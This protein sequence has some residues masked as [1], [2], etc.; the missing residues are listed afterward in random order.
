MSTEHGAGAERQV[1]AGT[2]NS[3][4]TENAVP[5]RR[6]WPRTLVNRWPT[7]MALLMTVTTLGGA[8]SDDGV[9]TFSG[10]LLLLPLLYLV[11][12]K[13]GRRRATWPLL[14]AGVAVIFVLEGLELIAPAAVFTAIA[15]VVLVWGAVDGQLRRSGVFRLQAL[16]MLGFGALA[17]IGLA[18]DPDLGRYAVAAGWFL[19]GVWDLVHLKRDKVVSRS[20]AEWCCV[21]DI[22]I[23][24]E[25]AIGF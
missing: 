7:A 17:L 13:L 4:R 16:G 6:E 11:V 2:E 5:G 22:V 21:V 3:A 18:V 23:A 19:H 25:L 24:I 1:G 10:I 12:A 15:L 14:V 8:G 9:A 20:F